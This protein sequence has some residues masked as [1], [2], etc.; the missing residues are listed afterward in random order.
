[1]AVYIMFWV[2]K[3]A[4]EK[5]SAD[6]S[7]TERVL[8]CRS[9]RLE[10]WL[11]PFLSKP[12]WTFPRVSLIQRHSVI[13]WMSFVTWKE[14]LVVPCGDVKTR[15][16]AQFAMRPFTEWL[17]FMPRPTIARLVDQPPT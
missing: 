12:F 3:N 15:S 5:F 11:V 16:H 6:F 2:Q 7:A 1:M 17:V 14:A 8:S 10:C 4:F 13:F 9:Q